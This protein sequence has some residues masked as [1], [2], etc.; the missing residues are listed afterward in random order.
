M[1]E[2]AARLKIMPPT[3]ASASVKTASGKTAS[4]KTASGES[5]ST[6]AASTAAVVTKTA[7]TATTKAAVIHFGPVVVL[8][9]FLGVFEHLVCLVDSLEPILSFGS[10][11]VRRALLLVGVA[12]A[13]EDACNGTC[14]N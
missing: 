14:W 1:E 8:A 3:G 4:G 11:L 12:G 13:G 2:K 5:A 6:E 7:K 10:L 9:A